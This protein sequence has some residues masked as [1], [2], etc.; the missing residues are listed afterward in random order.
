MKQVISPGGEDSLKIFLELQFPYKLE[1]LLNKN[2]I[3]FASNLQNNNIL[4]SKIS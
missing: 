4:I 2:A 1:A 3:Q